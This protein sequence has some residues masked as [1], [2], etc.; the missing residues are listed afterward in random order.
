M[1]DLDDIQEAVR[2]W[3]N[4]GCLGNK[5]LTPLNKVPVGFLVSSV[6]SDSSAIARS[7]DPRAECRDI[8]VFAGDS[9][10]SLATQCGISV[11]DLTRYNPGS[12]FCTSLIAKQYVCCSAGTLPDH[13][14]QPDANGNCYT[15][16][17]Q[18]DDG[19]WATGDAFG[20][21]E[22]DIEEYNKK[23]WGWAG[24]GQ[25]QFTQVICLSDGDPPFPPEI[26]GATCGPQVPSTVKPTDGTDWASL[27]PWPLNACSDVWGFCD[28]TEEFC[29]AT[30]ADTGAP[31]TAQ[32]IPM[33]VY[34]TAE[35]TLSTM[36][37]ARTSF[38]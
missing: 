18:H 9:C 3:T 5:D 1:S 2:T 28:I 17:T 19:C 13:S 7:L 15:Y 8:Q 37:L 33:G 12:D 32:P 26:D 36:S 25:M 31:G 11:A 38:V 6:L 29:T 20:I 10:P 22:S 30:P 24:C 23:T 35:L 34:P 27:N 16:T 14:P 21:T 4:A